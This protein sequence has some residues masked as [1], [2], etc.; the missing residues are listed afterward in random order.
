[1]ML[2]SQPAQGGFEG[3]VEKA[4]LEYLIQLAC[5]A[6]TDLLIK[7]ISGQN[8]GSIIVRGGTVI[9]A[10]LGDT[11]GEQAILAILQW[12]KGSFDFDATPLSSDEDFPVTVNRPWEFLLIEAIRLGDLAQAAGSPKAVQEG[13]TQPDTGESQAE[14]FGGRIAAILVTDLIQ[15]VCSSGLDYLVRFE[16]DLGNGLLA[17]SSGRI[18]HAETESLQGE[19]AFL[20]LVDWVRG[21]FKATVG[22]YDGAPTID[23]PTEILLTDAMRMRDERAG[24]PDEEDEDG[25]KDS[26]AVAI[27]KMKMVEKV[28]LAMKGDK[29]ARAVLIRDPS[30]IIQYAIIS[31]PRIS[32]GEVTLMA[33]SRSI[34]EEI[35]RR[36]ANSREWMKLYQIRFALASNPKTPVPI[37]AR[38]VPTL[39]AKD[40]KTLAKSKTVPTAVAQAAMRESKKHH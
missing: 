21:S 22:T 26:L 9:H 4:P 13:E 32:E 37:S 20:A 29:E 36:I 30:K 40:L 7:V 15:F 24:G 11:T 38:L 3:T 39:M 27:M 25:R 8:E 12:E 6:K 31:N 10:V 1:M 34:D 23:K 33:S 2:G 17:V 19:E 18:I 28:K 16:S 14:G 35:L 5:L